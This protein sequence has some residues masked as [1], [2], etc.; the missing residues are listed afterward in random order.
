MAILPEYP[1]TP[2]T[3]PELDINDP[4]FLYNADPNCDHDIRAKELWEG[5]GVCCTK[6]KGWFCY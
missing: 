2:I 3:K 6:C 4:D 5:G 1:E